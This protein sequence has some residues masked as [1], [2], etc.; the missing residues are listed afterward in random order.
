MKNLTKKL[1]ALLVTICIMM[2]LTTY[3]T[4]SLQNAPDLYKHVSRGYNGGSIGPIS[5][6]KA[7]LTYTNTTTKQVYLISL[8][9][10]ELVTNQSTYIIN[11]LLTGFNL[12]SPYLTA[13]TNAI[14]N[15]I[16]SNSMLVISGHSLG[17]M[18]AQQLAASPS[19]KNNY[20]ILNVVTFG[21]PL[22]SAGRREGTIRRLGDKNDWVPYLS[23]T[24]TI[25]FPW[26]VWGL[27]KEDGGYSS[28]DVM[29]SHI[30]SYKRNDVWGNYDVLGF[31]YTSSRIIFE[32]ED[33]SFY[34]AP[35]NP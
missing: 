26:Q 4:T 5:I 31:K 18:I 28:T 23:A 1:I 9:G 34:H 17:G 20:Q 15:N 30:E 29:G 35:T 3:A 11:D 16:P 13:A 7:S 8:S 2:P 12:G 24:G 19:I 32:E 10:T 25:L 14:H 22:I 27:N 6:A 33:L 21:S